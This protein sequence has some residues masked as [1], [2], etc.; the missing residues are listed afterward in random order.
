[1]LYQ[2]TQTND[3]FLDK[4]EARPTLASR[5]KID[6]LERELEL[7]DTVR[8]RTLLADEY[9]KSKDY[10]KAR[11][12]YES[13]LSGHASEDLSTIIKLVD[14]CFEE[15]DYEDC[16]NY[17]KQIN[18]KSLFDKSV[19]KTAYAWALYKEGLLS[20]AE[21]IFKEMD[22]RY[23]HYVQRLEF[24]KFFKVTGK[25]KAAKEVTRILM[26]EYDSMHPQ[27]QRQKTQIFREIKSFYDAI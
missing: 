24:A 23:S 13:C 27:E 3:A 12:L 2:L 5:R 10:P 14:I 8:N 20:E 4:K 16:I 11:Q 26:E 9:Y 15:G 6:H 18:G 22:A 1:M 21:Q 19:E 25:D 17:A 7:A